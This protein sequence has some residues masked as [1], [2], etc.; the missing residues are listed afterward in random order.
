MKYLLTKRL[1]AV[2]VMSVMT[3]LEVFSQ[4]IQ[5]EGVVVDETGE[6]VIGATVMEKGKTNGVVTDIDGRFSISVPSNG[7]LSVSYIGYA[8]QDV[9]VNGKTNHLITLKS[10][11]Q[12]LNEV[13]V[14]GYGTMKKSDLS[15][16]V[17]SLAAKDMDKSPVANLGQAIQ[18]KIAGLQVWMPASLATTSA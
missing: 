16:A 1:M 12:V 14:I 2:L 13:V 17:G 18:G 11:D 6:A 5:V 7:S 8:T 9:A 4:A 10:D 15:G 3:A